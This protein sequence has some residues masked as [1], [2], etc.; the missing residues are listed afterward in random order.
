MSRFEGGFVSDSFGVYVSSSL[1]TMGVCVASVT[2][3]PSGMYTSGV[4][5]LLSSSGTA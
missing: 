5:C 1:G 4:S 3:G 2:G